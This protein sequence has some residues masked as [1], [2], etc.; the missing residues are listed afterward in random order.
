MKC[1]NL[2]NAG[3]SKIM[4]ISNSAPHRNEAR[5][6]TITQPQGNHEIWVQLGEETHNTKLTILETVHE[7]KNEMARLR[8]DNTI[9]TLEQEKILKSLSDKQNHRQPNPSPE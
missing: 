1:T 6:E 5:L 7:L 8:D 3:D 2:L 4:R 9:L